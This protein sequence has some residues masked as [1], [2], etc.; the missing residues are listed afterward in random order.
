MSNKN[1]ALYNIVYFIAEFFALGTFVH[2][3]DFVTQITFTVLFK[4]S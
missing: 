1:L 3:S 2:W 4:I